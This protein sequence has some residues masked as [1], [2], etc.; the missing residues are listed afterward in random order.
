MDPDKKKSAIL[1][2]VMANI[3][4]M[5]PK[6]WLM[7]KLPSLRQGKARALPLLFEKVSAD[8]WIHKLGKLKLYMPDIWNRI[9]CF[10]CL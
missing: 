10:T 8:H 3:P 2:C 7:K 6:T 5:G 1:C 4:R 9:R